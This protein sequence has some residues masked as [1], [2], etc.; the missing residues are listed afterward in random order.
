MADV[1]FDEASS[2]G[3]A[4]TS[5]VY[6]L[7]TLLSGE[8]DYSVTSNAPPLLST[9][10]INNALPPTCYE[11]V[12]KVD[13]RAGEWFTNALEEWVGVSDELMPGTRTD[14]SPMPMDEGS[15]RSI[16]LNG[17]AP[18]EGEPLTSHSSAQDGHQSPA[19]RK[20][21]R[22]WK[23]SFWLRDSVNFAEWASEHEEPQSYMEALQRPAYR[24]WE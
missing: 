3:R 19:L 16:T 9:T 13:D 17:M 5:S 7:S 4:S 22:A 21:K 12:P 15:V 10:P 23:P 8:V 20:S 1:V 2:G 11:N 14:N 18:E 24:K 6:S